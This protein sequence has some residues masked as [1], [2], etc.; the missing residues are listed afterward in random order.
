MWMREKNSSDRQK[1]FPGSV[2]R[3]PAMVKVADVSGCTDAGT[4]LLAL[5]CEIFSI[6]SS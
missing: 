5:S 6:V 3:T 1:G 2:L 4:Y